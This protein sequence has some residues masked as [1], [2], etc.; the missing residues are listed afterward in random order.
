MLVHQVDVAQ[1]LLSVLDLYCIVCHYFS[2]H[3]PLLDIIQHH[4]T[5]YH[6]TSFNYYY[7]IDT[8]QKLWLATMCY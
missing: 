1:A 4:K 5:N 2:Y 6:Y 3:Y 8:H 7:F